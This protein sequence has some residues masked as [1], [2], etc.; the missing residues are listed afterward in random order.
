MALNRQSDMG[1]FGE[2]VDGYDTSFDGDAAAASLFRLAVRLPVALGQVWRLAWTASPRGAALLVLAQLAAG[3]ATA[4]ALLATAHALG[5]L[6]ASGPAPERVSDAVP[7]VVAA[8]VAT[9]VRAALE[10]VVAAAQARLSPGVRRVAEDRLHAAAVGAELGAF[11]DAEWHDTMA[12]ARDRGIDHTQLAL[13][14]AV[15]FLGAAVG[16]LVGVG[17]VT[18]LHPVLL[19]LLALSMAPQGWA[20]LSSARIGFVGMVRQMSLYRRLWL[21]ADLLTSREAAA[22]VRA[23]T[24]ERPLLGEFRRLAGLVERE[25]IRVGYAQTRVG[26]AGRALSG[27]AL[28][29]TYT[30]LGVLVHAQVVPLAAAGTALVAVRAA[31]TSL[32]TLMVAVDRLYEKSLYITDHQVFLAEAVARSRPSTGRPA[33]EGF[34]EIQ[35]RDV[36][37]W[38]PGSSKPALRG[39]DVAIR[40]GETVAL[41]GE[42]GSG[43]TTLA[44]LLA[45]LYLPDK[46]TVQWDG[47]DLAGVDLAQIREQVALVMQQPT[48]WPV[49]ARG[50]IV[51]GRSGHPDPDGSALLRAAHDSGAHAMIERL[52]YGYET[53]LSKKFKDGVDLSGGQWQRI[54]IARGFYRDARLLIADEPTAALDARAEQAVYENIRRLAAGRTVVLITHRL[55]SVR[56]C[57]RIVVLH[58][59]EVVQQGTHEQL[60]RAGGEYAD[61]YRIQAAAYADGSP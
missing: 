5:A 31:S 25:E 46:G 45:G 55:A 56:D 20:A 24:A 41:V 37:F 17:V 10:T 1:E 15:E 51:L 48:R 2:L 49:T 36:C 21:F 47:S 50:N 9:A 59:G 26:A 12:R 38:Y 29:A 27:L 19:P 3:V 13:G 44:L 35:L 28:A 60:M 11:D 43:K 16:L 7:S 61:M 18:G 6:F 52:P 4:L 8:V 40:K 32:A 54:G 14:H 23:C 53:L 42:N 33:P 30:A 39:V 34:T 57:D 58:Q 22:E